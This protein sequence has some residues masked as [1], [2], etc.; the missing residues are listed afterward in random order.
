MKRRS[1]ASTR[2]SI[3]Q[4]RLSMWSSKWSEATV[5]PSINSPSRDSTS[6]EK[7]P[8]EK[9]GPSASEIPSTPGYPQKFLSRITREGHVRQAFQNGLE[10]KDPPGRQNR[11]RHAYLRLARISHHLTVE[12]PNRPAITALRL[13]AVLKVGF[14]YAHPCSGNWVPSGARLGL[15]GLSRTSPR[16][17]VRRM[18]LTS[19]GPSLSSSPPT[20]PHPVKS[21]IDYKTG[22]RFH[23]PVTYRT[24]NGLGTGVVL[25]WHSGSCIVVKY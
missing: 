17:L 12:A 2:S 13:L 25:I 24:A 19:T 10:N 14:N 11:G 1:V 5:I 9:D 3:P 8:F 4:P 22:R 18:G 20:R 21:N 15:T 7:T 23:L 16:H 6:S